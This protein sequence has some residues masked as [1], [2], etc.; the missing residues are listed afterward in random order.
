MPSIHD[1]AWASGRATTHGSVTVQLFRSAAPAGDRW[2]IR[3]GGDS[4]ITH[5]TIKGD[6]LPPMHPVR[7]ALWL[8]QLLSG[9][10]WQ[11]TGI[12]VTPYNST[13]RCCLGVAVDLCPTVIEN[14][15]SLHGRVRGVFL[16]MEGERR[17]EKGYLTV[18]LR[19]WLGITQKFQDL[20]AALN[21]A[22]VPFEDIAFVIDLLV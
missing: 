3:T 14:Q 4:R 20:L 5:T 1:G 13:M 10:Y 19:E 17:G 16:R 7:K 12:L 8:A 2:E 18:G 22:K 11:A 21:D 6:D 15:V 9:A